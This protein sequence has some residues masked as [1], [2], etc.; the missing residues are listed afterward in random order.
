MLFAIK[1]FLTAKTA[2][3]GIESLWEGL[4]K[5]LAKIKEGL[6]AIVPEIMTSMGDFWIVLLPFAMFV[7][8]TFLLWLRRMVK[9]V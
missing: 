8:V 9:G 2:G 7:I 4:G 1:N 3:E 5:A 6:Y